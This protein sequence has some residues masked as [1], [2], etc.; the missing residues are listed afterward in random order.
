VERERMLIIEGKS[1]VIPDELADDP[2][3]MVNKDANMEIQK[4][5]SKVGLDLNNSSILIPFFPQT[6]EDRSGKECRAFEAAGREMGAGKASTC[7]QGSGTSGQETRA[8]A[9]A[10]IV[11]GAVQDGGRGK[12]NGSAAVSHVN[13]AAI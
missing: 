6:V 7:C 2:I 8:A 1:D 3:F 4:E 12:G 9:P 13:S 11:G 10:E 5:R